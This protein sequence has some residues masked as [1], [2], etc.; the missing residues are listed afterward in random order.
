MELKKNP[1]RKIPAKRMY[2]FITLCFRWVIKYRSFLEWLQENLM[3]G[4]ALTARYKNRAVPY[5]K[6]L[7]WQGLVIKKILRVLLVQ[8]FL[9]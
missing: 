4:E 8:H 1:E 9:H 3:V 5:K 7:G 2:F 6:A